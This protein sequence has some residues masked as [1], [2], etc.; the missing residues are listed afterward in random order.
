MN[1]AAWLPALT[2]NVA[3]GDFGSIEN[4]PFAPDCTLASGVR[5]GD[6]ESKRTRS[7]ADVSPAK[8][9]TVARAIGFP[10][11]PMSVPVIAASTVVAAKRSAAKPIH[12]MLLAVF[13]RD[14]CRIFPLVGL[15]VRVCAVRD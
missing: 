2:T 15:R 14:V 12:E 9:W 11:T 4:D 7:A 8:A 1:A 13:V 5:S 3:S 10:S 6:E